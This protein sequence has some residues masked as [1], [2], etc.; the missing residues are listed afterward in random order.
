LVFFRSATDAARS[1]SVFSV[2]QHLRCRFAGLTASSNPPLYG[3]KMT[4]DAEQSALIQIESA[5]L[6]VMLVLLAA[7]DAVKAAGSGDRRRA[8]AV[9]AIEHIAGTMEMVDSAVL[10]K[11]ASVD[12]LSEGL[13]T[14]LITARAM[15][16]GFQLPLYVDAKEFLAPIEATVDRILHDARL[17]MH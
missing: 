13:L 8:E 6:R 14:L 3:S 10:L 12:E 9:D 17:H 1:K 7:S 4:D 16:T 5:R 15:A 11:L 2:I